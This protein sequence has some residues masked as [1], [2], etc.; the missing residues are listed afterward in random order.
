V[1]YPHERGR[2]GP[3]FWVSQQHE[4]V[5]VRSHFIAAKVVEENAMISAKMIVFIL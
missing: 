5:A 3:S 1:I 4:P 2:K